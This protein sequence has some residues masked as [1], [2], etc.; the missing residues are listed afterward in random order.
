MINERDA[1]AA[2]LAAAALKEHKDQEG[3]EQEAR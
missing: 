1:L 2:E 3:Q